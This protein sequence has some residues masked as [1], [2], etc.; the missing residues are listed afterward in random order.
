LRICLPQQ[1]YH[2][3]YHLFV[4]PFNTDK[5]VVLPDTGLD[6]TRDKKSVKIAASGPSNTAGE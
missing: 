5:P 4:D 3:S 1:A 6:T 2:T